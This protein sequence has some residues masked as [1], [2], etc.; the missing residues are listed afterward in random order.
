[1]A[2]LGMLLAIGS[3]RGSYIQALSVLNRDLWCRR[4]VGLLRRHHHGMGS[5]EHGTIENYLL[6]ARSVRAIAA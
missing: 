5:M 6:Q 4:S 2:A 1:M 3:A